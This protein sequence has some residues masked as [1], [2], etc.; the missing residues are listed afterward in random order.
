MTIGELK[1]LQA[2]D[3]WVDFAGQIIEVK[4]I[5]TRTLKNRM[6]T[7]VRIK[8]KTD[9]IGAWLYSDQ[10]Q[11]TLNQIVQGRGMLKEY[12]DV[13]YLDYATVKNSQEASQDAGQPPQQRNGKD[14]SI[15]RQASFKAACEFAG[16]SGIKDGET[17]IEVAI[18]GHYFIETGKNFYRI[19]E[20][21]QE[22]TNTGD[23]SPDDIPF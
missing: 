7:K 6:M 4:E 18:A 15:E 20:P 14:T 3:G 9:E 10:Q 16:R 23:E 21:A 12:Q 11:F 13:R 2:V 1:Q 5:K 22:I 17:L 8:D 19:P